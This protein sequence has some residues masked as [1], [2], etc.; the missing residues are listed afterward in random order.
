[1][2]PPLKMSVNIS[3]KQFAQREL[4]S[5]VQD[6][7]KDAGIDP[8]TLALEITESM[9]MDNVEMAVETMTMLRG[10]GIQIHID[11]FGPGIHR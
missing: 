1:M 6:I 7:V 10:M 4:A 8:H 9:I 5:R 3:G 2:Q 11:D